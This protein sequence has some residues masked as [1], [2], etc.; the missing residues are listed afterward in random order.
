MLASGTL[1]VAALTCLS[2]MIIMSV[3]RQRRML[4]KMP[5]GP[6]PLPFIGNLLELDTEKF[7]DSLL[8]IR[9]QYG[10][11]FTIHVGPRPAVVLWGYDAVKE[12]LIDQAEEFSGRGQQG[13]FD[14]FFKGYGEDDSRG[15]RIRPG[16]C[17]SAGS[18]LFE[19]FHSVMKHLPGSHHQAY[20]EMQGLE[21]FVA[22]KVEQ[23]QR[24]LDP[25]SP[26]DF[27]DSFLIRMQ[28]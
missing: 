1:L 23:N 16:R 12:A 18:M 20:K 19:M 11:V 8:K 22:R 21:D 7:R 10:P 5:P 9:E 14:W 4:E 24:T 25:N 13:F 2:V 6:T 27:I 28:Q 3:W 26:R 15:G 17:V